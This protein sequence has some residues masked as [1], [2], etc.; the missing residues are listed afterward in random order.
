MLVN[1]SSLAQM[2]GSLFISMHIPDLHSQKAEDRVKSR[3][4]EG[5]YGYI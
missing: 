2:W 4:A 3:E 5:V 1:V